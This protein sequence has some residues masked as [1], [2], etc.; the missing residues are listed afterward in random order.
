MEGRAKVEVVSLA[1][2]F[3]LNFSGQVYILPNFFL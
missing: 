2:L 1:P 3:P